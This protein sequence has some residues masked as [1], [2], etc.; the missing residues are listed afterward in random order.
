LSEWRS[1]YTIP[2]A[3]LQPSPVPGLGLSWLLT[4]IARLYTSRKFVCP[5]GPE[6]LFNDLT[7]YHLADYCCRNLFVRPKHTQSSRQLIL[8]KLVRESFAYRG[9]VSVR[10]RLEPDHSSNASGSVFVGNGDNA[11]FRNACQF[12]Q[13]CFDLDN[14][15]F[16][17]MKSDDL[18]TLAGRKQLRKK[19]LSRTYSLSLHDPRS[20]IHRR[21]AFHS[22][23]S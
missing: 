10:A 7:P 12:C 20:H 9:E 3:A 5:I 4:N 19:G 11:G 15:N 22:R 16:I 6:I 13:T 18:V 14:G 2:L 8:G 23:Q 17:A 21:P 1:D